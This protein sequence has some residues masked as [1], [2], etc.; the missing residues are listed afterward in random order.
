MTIGYRL[1]HV[2][3][4]QPRADG[5][6]VRWPH[7]RCRHLPAGQCIFG[8]SRYPLIMDYVD[9]RY[10]SASVHSWCAR[11]WL[12]N[13]ASSLTPIPSSAWVSMADTGMSRSDRRSRLPARRS[14]VRARARSKSPSP[15]MLR[16]ALRRPLA[17]H[18]RVALHGAD[19]HRGPT[20]RRSRTGHRRDRGRRRRA[21]EVSLWT[22]A[23]S[24]LQQSWR[25]SS[26]VARATAVSFK[27][28]AGLHHAL[29]QS[30]RPRTGV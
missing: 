21:A 15:Q 5:R 29:P 8:S 22:R 11:R 30:H 12:T 9:T 14:L 19:L 3:G 20:G 26:Q 17:A 24:P 7:R 23:T 1:P 18:L 6:A 4:P 2:K 27:L 16:L 25:V 28:T 13:C 10:E